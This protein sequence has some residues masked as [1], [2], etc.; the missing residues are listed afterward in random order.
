MTITVVAALI[1]ERIRGQNRDTFLVC[2][3]SLAGAFPGRWEFPGGKAEAGEELR[4]ALRREL[5]EELGIAAEIGNEFW[6]TEHQYRN[7]PSVRVIFFQVSGYSGIPENR[8]FEKIQWT[9]VNELPNLD[10]LEADQPLLELLAARSMTGKKR[11]SE[12]E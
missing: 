3:R 9:P 7:G 2:Q 12:G 1:Q 4:A 10:F 6:R 5:E 8:V 11:A